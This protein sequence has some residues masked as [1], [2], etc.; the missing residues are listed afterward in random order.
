MNRYDILAINETLYGGNNN[1]FNTDA[2]NATLDDIDSS[3]QERREENRKTRLENCGKYVLYNVNQHTGSHY[4]IRMYCGLHRECPQCASRRG[5][6]LKKEVVD[7]SL[8]NWDLRIVE[9]SESEASELCKELGDKT[10]YRRMPQENGN[11]IVLFD[12]DPG[13]PHQIGELLTEERIDSID[14]TS[15]SRTPEKKRITG[16]LAKPG[17]APKVKEET[18][19]ILVTSPLYDAP[20]RV[21]EKAAQLAYERTS[22]LDPKT[23]DAVEKAIEERTRVYSQIMEYWGYKLIVE[24]VKTVVVKI[25]RINWVKPIYHPIEFTAE[26]AIRHPIPPPERDYIH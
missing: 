25:K 23:A 10:T 11:V 2:I 15:L 5:Y 22:Y 21:Q 19:Q 24:E 9:L 8:D 14:W 7:Y 12:D 18:A 20:Q 26:E 3:T 16:S 1:V 4:F 17:G 6:Q 13:N